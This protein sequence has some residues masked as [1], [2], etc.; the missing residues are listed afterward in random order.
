MLKP[1]LKR[2]RGKL[3]AARCSCFTQRGTP[4]SDESIHA[5]DVDSEHREER[6]ECLINAGL[7]PSACVAKQIRSHCAIVPSDPQFTRSPGA[8]PLLALEYGWC[9]SIRRIYPYISILVPLAMSCGLVRNR[10]IQADDL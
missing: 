8:L 6:W 3:V 7:S 4:I 9:S 1:I 2:H 5:P 10:L